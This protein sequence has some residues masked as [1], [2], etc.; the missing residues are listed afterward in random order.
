MIE[1]EFVRCYGPKMIVGKNKSNQSAEADR[2]S[3]SA[4]SANFVE[5]PKP[6]R[7]R[8]ENMPRMRKPLGHV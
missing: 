3:R 5:N 7:L 1:A 4:S 8:L 6:A 2:S